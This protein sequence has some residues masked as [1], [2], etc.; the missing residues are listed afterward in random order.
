MSA[1]GGASS[2]HGVRGGAEGFSADGEAL[3]RR[4]LEWLPW[5]EAVDIL[6]AVADL[7]QDMGEPGFRVGVVEAACCEHT[8]PGL[9][10]ARATET[11][12]L[13]V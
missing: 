7:N 13:W 10:R 8:P 12:S 11:G 3:V 9:A 6:A 4:R 1:T 5:H 2:R